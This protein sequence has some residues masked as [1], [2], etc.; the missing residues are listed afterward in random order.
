MITESS[1][2]F[3]MS[4]NTD[5]EFLEMLQFTGHFAPPHLADAID[6]NPDIIGNLRDAIEPILQN[7][8]GD[9]FIPAIQ[10]VEALEEL[11]INGTIIPGD[12]TNRQ[13][14]D[15]FWDIDGGVL[16]CHLHLAPAVIATLFDDQMTRATLLVNEVV[17]RNMT[18]IYTMDGHGRFLLCMIHALIVAG[19]DPDVYNINIVE[20]DNVCHRWHELFF[21]ANVYVTLNNVLNLLYDSAVRHSDDQPAVEDQ[22]ELELPNPVTTFF[23]L[24]FC[25]IG[26]SVNSYGHEHFIDLIRFYAPLNNIMLSFSIRGMN[27]YSPL[28]DLVSNRMRPFWQGVTYRVNFFTGFIRNHSADLP[29]ANNINDVHIPDEEHSVVTVT[30]AVAATID[31]DD[32]EVFMRRNPKKRRTIIDDLE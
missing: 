1:P 23:Y 27:R 12:L 31:D 16:F 10:H 7:E 29:I 15:A 20:I 13:W 19:E 5:I 9:G 11:V 32:D 26:Q 17:Q 8:A 25:S 22:D 6:E 18:D 24:N 28:G 30:V 2:R 4:L 14:H 21:P 3:I